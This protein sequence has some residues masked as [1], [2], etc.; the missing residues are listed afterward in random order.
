[1]AMLGEFRRN[2]YS[3]HLLRTY[4]T[5]WI[6]WLIRMRGHAGAIGGAA[7]QIS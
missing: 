3:L 1:M 6:M 2:G 5:F 4:V 7:Y